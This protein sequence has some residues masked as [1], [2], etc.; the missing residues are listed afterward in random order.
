MH[1]TYRKKHQRFIEL[2]HTHFAE[3]IEITGH[4][5]GLHI[6]VTIRTDQSSE[7]LIKLA[8]KEGARVYDFNLMWMKQTHRRCP[9]LYLGF[10]T[11]RFITKV[12]RFR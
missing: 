2:M 12:R 11:N 8:A 6:L 10:G 4:S 9:Q 3:R 5:A 1:N 7:V